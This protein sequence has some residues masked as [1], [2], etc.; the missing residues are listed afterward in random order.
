MSQREYRGSSSFYPATARLNSV[1]PT[2]YDVYDD[3]GDLVLSSITVNRH[4]RARTMA[5]ERMSRRDEWMN[6]R[7][8]DMLEGGRGASPGHFFPRSSTE[9]SREILSTRHTPSPVPETINRMNK[10][11]TER[12]KE[13]LHA[14]KYKT[15]YPETYRERSSSYNAVLGRYMV[16]ADSP[17]FRYYRY[18]NSYA[19]L[20]AS[21]TSVPSRYRSRLSDIVY[22]P[23]TR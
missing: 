8:R 2:H 15:M 4:N 16:N 6:P 1:P 10:E 5:R 11:F 17:G 18:G 12:V 22:V 7:Y 14:S 23:S 3:E 21:M 19:D 9:Y 20:P 13:K